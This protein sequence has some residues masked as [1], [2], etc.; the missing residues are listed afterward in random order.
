MSLT[1]DR[2]ICHNYGAGGTSI[3]WKACCL[4]LSQHSYRC[5]I[6]VQEPPGEFVS[7]R[8]WNSFQEAKAAAPCHLDEK[9]SSS[10]IDSKHLSSCRDFTS[11]MSFSSV[12]VYLTP[13]SSGTFHI[14]QYHS[15]NWALVERES[16]AK[17]FQ[18]ALRKNNNT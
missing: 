5:Q 16:R 10:T 14:N 3:N 1:I 9:Q 12:F 17:T 6:S 18:K 2:H 11:G 7:K 4:A 13:A 15:F 8:K